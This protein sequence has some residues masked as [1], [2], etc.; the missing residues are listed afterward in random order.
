MGKSR[1]YD[2]VESEYDRLLTLARDIWEQP[3]LGLEEEHA[4]Y[5]LRTT[6]AEAGFEVER[7]VGGMP[8]AF[9]ASYGTGDPTIGILGEYDALP[10]L[11]QTV[12]T[13][14]EPVEVGEPGHGCGHNLFGVAGVGAALA[15][16]E[17]LDRGEIEGTIRF[18]GTP[19]EE[20]IVGKVYMARAGVF[21]D[22]DAAL[23][24][25]PCDVTGPQRTSS[26]AVDSVKYSFEGTPAHAA[27][28]PTAGRSALDAVQL[29]NT[30]V[31]YLREHIPD[32]AR[33]HY[34]ITEG[35]GAPNVVP[36]EATAWYFVR[37]PTRPQVD[38]LS[39]RVQQIAEGA[40]L[41]TDTTV[42]RNYITGAYE[43]LTN[44]TLADLLWETFEE[45]GP[46]DYSAADREF[47]AELHD[48]ID[49]AAL[50]ARLKDLPADA[51][52]AV[53]GESLYSTPL[54]RTDD[55]PLMLGSTDVSDVSWITPTAQF[56]AASWPVGT[57][58]HTWQA[59][60]ASGGFGRKS[61][62]YAAKVLAGTAYDLF[63]DPKRLEA[64]WAEFENATGDRSYESPLPDDAEPP[65]GVGFSP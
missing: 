35:G 26:L 25:H 64:A 34:T 23:T 54:E 8:T 46:I 18:Y 40:A 29:M 42:T 57:R 47:A 62:P 13:C 24:W 51:A 28:S 31:E 45:L 5:R 12:S 58:P 43:L 9:V 63:T 65:F 36:A 37:A 10:E 22:L 6:L 60:A 50:D 39:Q 61:A 44:D 20:T 55:A 2:A 7:G 3:E 11:S 32:K 17:A 38:R 30:G 53:E 56:R 21:D 59:V 52:R 4:A 48:T 16:K 27:Q 19:A 49:E 14:R 1:V 15:L 33:I 41:M